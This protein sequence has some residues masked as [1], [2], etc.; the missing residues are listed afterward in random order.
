MK[1]R[2]G[3]ESNRDYGTITPKVGIW[4]WEF[5]QYNTTYREAVFKEYTCTWEICCQTKTYT[6]EKN[7][8]G[9]LTYPASDFTTPAMNMNPSSYNYLAY[10]STVFTGT[11]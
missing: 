6:M 11:S 10:T 8:A 3:I 7:S 5:S 4:Y 9:T 2:C 1:V